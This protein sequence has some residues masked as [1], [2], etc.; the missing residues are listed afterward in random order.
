MVSGVQIL[1]YIPPGRRGA[2]FL[3]RA[4]M[5]SLKNTIIKKIKT[6]VCH[7]I[8]MARSLLNWKNN[9]NKEFDCVYGT[10]N[11]T[12][13]HFEIP[14]CFWLRLMSELPRFGKFLVLNL[15]CCCL[16]FNFTTQMTLRHLLPMPMNNKIEYKDNQIYSK[17]VEKD[18]QKG[19]LI[20]VSCES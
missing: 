14:I 1:L 5:Y 19:S 6:F 9:T 11:L 17:M 12:K 20:S 4:Q 7:Y 2:L 10:S 8:T 3:L 13:Q 16:T 15:G 18:L